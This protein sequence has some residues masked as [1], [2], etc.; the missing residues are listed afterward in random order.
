VGFALKLGAA[1]ALSLSALAL[2]C[3]GACLLRIP[4]MHGWMMAHHCP[5]AMHG[6]SRVPSMK[7]SDEGERVAV[8]ED[9]RLN[10]AAVPR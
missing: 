4:P 2:A 1:G 3:G 5:L 6:K 7:M 10:R 9:R 8:G